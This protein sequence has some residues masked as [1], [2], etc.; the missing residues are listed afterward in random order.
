ML[1]SAISMR[2]VVCSFI[3]L[4]AM[5][6]C[7]HRVYGQSPSKDFF[8]PQ[9]VSLEQLQAR[10]TQARDTVLVIN[11]W[12]TWCKPCIQELPAFE[13]LRKEYAEHIGSKHTRPLHIILVSLNSVKEMRI[14]ETF[15]RK[16]R[17]GAESLLLSA[18]NPNIWIDA[19]VPTWSGA[20]P[21]TWIG[22]PASNKK[23]FHEG[24]VTYQELTSLL[25]KFVL[26]L[27]NKP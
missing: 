20:I 16:R 22:H 21:A 1:F 6:Q 9:V 15:L 11:F 13:R 19:I 7:Y 5:T 18:G 14:V 10:I 24:E 2:L 25:D 23:I 12:A 8:T 4:W 26:S 27:S 17:Y 3:I